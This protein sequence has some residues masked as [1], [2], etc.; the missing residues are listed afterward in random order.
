MMEKSFVAGSRVPAVFEGMR[1]VCSGTLP[2]EPAPCLSLLT[3][4]IA[5]TNTPIKTKN[6]Q[7]TIIVKNVSVVLCLEYGTVNKDT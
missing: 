4:P 3:P 2:L 7:E 6:T 5:F 1:A